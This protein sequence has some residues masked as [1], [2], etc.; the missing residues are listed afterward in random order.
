MNK[1]NIVNCLL[2]RKC[3]L[4]CSYCQISGNIDTPLKPSDYPGSKYY[5]ANE[6]DTNWWI[7][8][9][10]KL[11]RHN[12]DVFFIL[13]G[14]EPF[15]RW[16]MLAEIVLHLN[17]IG[18]YYTIISSCNAGI[19]KNI[20]NF[21]GKVSHVEGFTASIDPGFYLKDPGTREEMQ[22]DEIYKSSTGYRM[23]K[24]LMR[25]GIV[26]DPV[27]EITCDKDTIFLLHETI[28][29][30]TADGIVSD[31]TMIDIAKTN[32]YDFSNITNPVNLVHPTPEVLKVFDDII[33]DDSLKVHMKEYLL[34]RIFKYLPSNM[35]CDLEKNLSNISIDSDGNLRTCLR[36]RGRFVTKFSAD[37]LLNDDGDLS[38]EF[39]VIHEALSADKKS[40]CKGCMWSCIMMSESGDCNGIIN[41]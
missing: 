7:N 37:A 15:L 13:Y 20:Y 5:Y 30:L 23:L 6:K 41:H 22:D 32:Y 31:I 39:E 26:K 36:I 8:V 18:A 16:E 25:R 27:A 14:G 4:R 19:E 1:I 2:T 12:K 35:N 38:E 29:R 33:K 17:R 9:L 40:L 24:E 11:W 34:P 21:F 3:N 28:K 10:T